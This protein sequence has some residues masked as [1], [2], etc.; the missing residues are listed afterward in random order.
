[1]SRHTGRGLDDDATELSACS[2]PPRLTLGGAAVVPLSSRVFLCLPRPSLFSLLMAGS[3]RCS[4]GCWASRGI[5]GQASASCVIRR[6]LVSAYGASRIG[7]PTHKYPQQGVIPVWSFPLI[8][9][10]ENIRSF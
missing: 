7:S 3:R 2:F 1:M 9:Y 4:L 10:W 6:H 8:S 5:S